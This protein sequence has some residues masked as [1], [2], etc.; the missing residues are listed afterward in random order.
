MKL[1]H[2]HEEKLREFLGIRFLLKELLK[3]LFQTEGNHSRSKLGMSGM[4]ILS[5]GKN[6]PQL[7]LLNIADGSAKWSRYSGKR[8]GNFLQSYTYTFHMAQKHYSWVMSTKRPVH[9]YLLQLYS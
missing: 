1:R 7:E 3:E 2:F 8:V 5:T 4:I 9:E 6:L